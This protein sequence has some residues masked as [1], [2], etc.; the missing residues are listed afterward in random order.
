MKTHDHDNAHS[1]Q[2]Q[3]ATS[4]QA[5]RSHAVAQQTEHGE[6]A[7][8]LAQAGPAIFD[9]RLN[10]SPRMVAQRQRLGAAFGP[11]AQR[12]PQRLEEELPVQGKALA[13][14]QPVQREAGPDDEEPAVQAKQGWAGSGGTIQAQTEMPAEAN[15]TGIPNQLKSGVEALSGMDMSDVRVH[16]NSDKPAQLNALA[17]AQG[18]EIHLGPGQE[19]H[20]PHEAW[21][22]V[23]QR[24]GRV[25][26]TMQMAGVGVN[27]DVRLEEEA[28]VMGEKAQLSRGGKGK[29]LTPYPVT[30]CLPIQA[31]K[32]T[33]KRRQEKQRRLAAIDRL[34][35]GSTGAYDQ[36]DPEVR[37]GLLA[38]DEA[39]P[40]KSAAKRNM[41]TRAQR[42]KEANLPSIVEVGAGTGSAS[43]HLRGLSRT[44]RGD[45]TLPYLATD[46][47]QIGG[48]G[49]FL[50]EAQKAHI[51]A[52]GGVDANRLEEH[53]PEGSLDEVIGANAYGDKEHPG[54]SYGL[55]RDTDTQG[56]TAWDDRFLR[57]AHKVLKQGGTARL[58]A[59]SNFLADEHG[60][61][62]ERRTN[63][64][65]SP[66]REDLEQAPG[67]GYD[68]AVQSAVQPPGVHFYRPDTHPGK[69]K[70][71]GAYNTELT[72]TKLDAPGVLEVESSA[73]DSDT[74]ELDSDEE[75]HSNGEL[76]DFLL[77]EQNK[78]FNF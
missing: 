41:A 49:N 53:F 13:L 40:R 31:A 55:V 36:L 7:T 47:S 26:A 72:F 59:R 42:L 8:Q 24:Q 25:Q 29:E 3:A 66:T 11:V 44:G 22:V 17:Y 60:E 1:A 57:S 33:K 39:Q 12:E 71:L 18:N 76:E 23:Q 67:L 68:V 75:E 64:Y 38:L 37:D 16:R 4:Q 2:R 63:K 43:V 21:H 62:G 15:F 10:L 65:L 34:N 61:Q 51:P 5:T 46:V 74:S 48:K 20:L 35:R 14:Q 19:Q 56:G 73:E 52:R 70:E 58:L 69:K 30:P 9:H 54:A 32:K 45:D 6:A 28:D 27:D 77:K 78:R 50:R